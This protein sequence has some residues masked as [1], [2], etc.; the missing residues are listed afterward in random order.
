MILTLKTIWE[1]QWTM[2]LLGMTRDCEPKETSSSAFFK[3]SDWKR[4]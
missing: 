1:K 3:Y 2:R 4:N